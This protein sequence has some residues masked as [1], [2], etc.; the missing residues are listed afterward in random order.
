MITYQMV[1]CCFFL[2]FSSWESNAY[3]CAHTCAQHTDG[4]LLLTK[5][6]TQEGPLRRR[7]P[8][9]TRHAG[10]VVQLQLSGLNILLQ[11]YGWA[12]WGLTGI[13]LLLHPCISLSRYLLLL[14]KQGRGGK[15]QNVSAERVVWHPQSFCS[16]C[17]SLMKLCWNVRPISSFPSDI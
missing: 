5:N 7:N 8:I 17:L 15:W 2:F 4:H 16:C 10:S 13:E 11:D 6:A 14:Q 3:I 1:C 9:Q 12:C